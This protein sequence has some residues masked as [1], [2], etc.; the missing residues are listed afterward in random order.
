MKKSIKQLQLE[1]LEDMVEYYSADPKK[2]EIMMK[3]MKYANIFQ[4]PKSQRA[5]RLEGKSP[6]D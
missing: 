2:E 4:S 5:A 3:S 1:F 6:N